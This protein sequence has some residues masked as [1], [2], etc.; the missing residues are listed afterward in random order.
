[1]LALFSFTLGILVIALNANNNDI[2]SDI[3]HT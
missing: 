2:C 3:I 1:M